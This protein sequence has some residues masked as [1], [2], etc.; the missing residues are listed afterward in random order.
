M[1]TTHQERGG[2]IGAAEGRDMD[3]TR[4]AR[5]ALSRLFEPLDPVGMLLVEAFGPLEAL[6]IAS[7]QA[8]ADD[9][10]A[11][12]RVLDGAG[13]GPAATLQSG[14]GKAGGGLAAALERWSP[15]VAHLA[16]E[17]DLETIARFGGRLVIP[18]DAEWPVG[19]TELGTDGPLCLWVRGEEPLPDTERCVA[20]VGSRDATGY[21]LSVAGEL[22]RGLADFG[23]TVVSGGAYGID[24]QAHRAA[25][26]SSGPAVPTMAVLAGG[27]DRYYPSGHEELLREVARRGHLISE[28]P[29]GAAPSKHR[30]LKR[31]RLIAAMSMLTVVVEARWR[32]GA[33]STA[34]RAVDLGRQVAA[35][36]GSV[37]SAN[38][39]GCHGLLRDGAM[40]VT[41]AKEA[42]ELIAPAGEGLPEERDT[43]T[44]PHDGL[45]LVDLM[46][47]EA[48]PVRRGSQLEHLAVVAG[49]SE[50]EV[51]AGLGRLSLLGMAERS[52]G[53]WRRTREA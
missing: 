46:V 51:R 28:L 45:S 33:L 49:L 15:R 53:G 40:C 27:V 38:S 5:A 22:A 4:I 6:R 8:P 32:S 50:A 43:P 44:K 13:R 10:A 42:Y 30:F 2:W 25:L 24:G 9:L 16:P 47:L 48:L 11:L 17:R 18:E 12:A 36:P 14:T 52:E 41:E 34:R 7:G 21:G 19:L 26:T 3:Q 29:P 35:V 1:K 37:Y 39:A 23:V 31:N 20:V